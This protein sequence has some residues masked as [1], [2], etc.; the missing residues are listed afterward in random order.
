MNEWIHTLHVVCSVCSTSEH[1]SVAFCEYTA[2][3]IF[4]LRYV[5]VAAATLSGWQRYYYGKYKFILFRS[6][7]SSTTNASSHIKQFA[8][9]FN[10]QA[11]SARCEE[12]Y[13]IQASCLS[14]VR[15]TRSTLLIEEH[16]INSLFAYNF[17]RNECAQHDSQ[18]SSSIHATSFANL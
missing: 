14:S 9:G 11:S 1:N 15:D 10:V 12:H 16:R 4:T 8:L 18:L 17:R 3:V 2:L 5:N 7:S 13:C 6:S